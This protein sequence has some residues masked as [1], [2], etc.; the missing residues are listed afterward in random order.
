MISRQVEELQEAMERTLGKGRFHHTVGVAYT[1]AALAMVYEVDIENAL[2]AGMLHDCGKLMSSQEMG[3][4]CEEHSIEMNEIE[5]KNPGLLHGKIGAYIAKEKYG[6]KNE[7][8]LNAIT[9]HTT[10]RPAMSALEKIVFIADYIEPNREEIPDLAQIRK[11]SFEKIDKCLR[12]ILKNTLSYLNTKNLAI[13]PMTQK[14]YEYYKK[15]VK[16]EEIE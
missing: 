14:T 16:K 3:S 11:L 15:R 8:V 2:I 1:A 4:F 13:D 9:Y 12:K 7:D 5:K 10:G 6:V